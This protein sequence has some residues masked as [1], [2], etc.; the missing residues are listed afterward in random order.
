MTIRK[1]GLV[2]KMVL[3]ILLQVWIFNSLYLFRYA[4]P[5]PYVLVL[6]LLPIST[7]KGGMT[8]LGGVVGLVLD[9]LSGT[10]GLHT[11]SFTCVAF[12]RNDL[13]I[14]FVDSDTETSLPFNS[15]NKMGRSMLLLLELI[16][17]HHIIFFGL[18]AIGGV[19][20]EYISLRFVSSLFFTFLLSF[21][22]I[23]LFTSSGKSSS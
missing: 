11:A 4:T 5:Y 19:S 20:W 22:L 17:L 6:L 7:S 12:L 9:M 1:I 2:F 18:D 14:P 3:L 8:L 10:P 15:R 13:L 16:T 21:I 23:V